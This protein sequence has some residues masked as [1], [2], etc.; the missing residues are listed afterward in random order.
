M[1]VVIIISV[2]AAIAYPAY[3]NYTRESKRA[4]AHTALMRIAALEEKHFSD[5]NVYA[6][7][8]TTLGYAAHPAMSNEGFWAVTVTAVGPAAFTL[9]ASPAGSHSD[10]DCNTITLT[11]AGM[12]TPARCW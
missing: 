2:L 3:Q 4:D 11:S 5:N 10:P 6:N 9:I 8:T 7:S 12:K 1:I